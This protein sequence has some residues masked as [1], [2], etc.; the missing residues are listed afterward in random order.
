MG[1]RLHWYPDMSASGTGNGDHHV[2]SGQPCGA[3]RLFAGLGP[4]SERGHTYWGRLRLRG[5]CGL[6]SG[7]LLPSNQKTLELEGPRT[8]PGSHVCQNN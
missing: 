7:T 4:S 1:D 5:R 3:V 6:L 2:I 8:Q